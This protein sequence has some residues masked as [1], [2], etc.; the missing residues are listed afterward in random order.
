[1]PETSIGTAIRAGRLCWHR[2]T[3]HGCHIRISDYRT[4]G[5]AYFCVEL[6]PLNAIPARGTKEKAD[7]FYALEDDPGTVSL[8]GWLNGII[9]IHQYVAVL[10][11]DNGDIVEELTG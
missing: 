4:R 11:N 9:A 6:C 1:M 8:M 3:K 10:V 5:G 7:R 2:V